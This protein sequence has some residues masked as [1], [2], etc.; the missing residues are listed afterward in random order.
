MSFQSMKTGTKLGGGFFLVIL[1]FI[2]V[3][4]YQIMSMDNLAALEG[5]SAQ[6]AVNAMNINSV[7]SRLEF[8]ASVFASAVINRDMEA[9]KKAFE[10]LKTQAAKDVE[11]VKG[12]AVTPEEKAQAEKFGTLYKE[13][14]NIFESKSLPILLKEQSMESRMRD[15]LLIKDVAGRVDS[16]YAIVAD[17][18]INRDLAASAREVEKAKAEADKDLEAVRKLADT[19]QE[20]QLA[21]TFSAAYAKYFDLIET[22]LMPALRMLAE[23]D[24]AG[25]RDVDAQ[26]DAARKESIAPL[27]AFN[28]SL[29]AEANVVAEDE[30]LLMQYD[31]EL[32]VMKDKTMEPLDAILESLT[33]ESEL[34]AERFDQVQAAAVKASI[35]GSV[36]GLLLGALIAFL[37]TR[38]LLR[39]LGG[40]PRDIA[41]T[42]SRVAVGDLNMEFHSQAKEGSVYEAMRQMV[43]AEKNV[44]HVAMKL[45][46]GDLRVTVN[47][48]SGNDE[49]MRS[50]G[51]MIAKLSE[52]VQEVSSG[53]ENVASGSEEMSA[54]SESLSQGASEQASAVEECSSSMEEMTSSINQ[55][56]DNAKQTETIAVKAAQDARESGEAVTSTVAAMKEIAGKISIIE[57]IARQTD[58]LAL[59][60]AIE[61]ARAG[62]HGKGFA[63]VASE[64]RKLAE[65][66]QT[67]AAEINRL[68]RESTTVA[69]QAGQ[70]LEKLVPDIQKTSDL[71]QEIS[72]ASAEQSTGAQQVNTALQQLDQVIQQ[73]AAASEELASTSEELSSQAEQ[74]QGS[75]GFFK[76]E[77]SE[78]KRLAPAASRTPAKALGP[79]GKKNLA[80]AKSKAKATGEFKLDLTD[81]EDSGDG[82]FERF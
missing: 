81:G 45:A 73:N 25:I 1:I 20:R 62:D 42:A 68:S 76:V 13:Y 57:E 64:V 58:L 30:K 4:A 38:D 5:E 53:A 18:V 61:A 33:K 56:A 21:D 65:R 50:L 19:D 34:A 22:R 44:A 16:L 6:L 80:A 17:A 15:A 77:G 9:S 70:L 74:L 43:A 26:I 12:L 31:G 28:A 14:L 54:S 10:E 29:E 63:V 23:G 66:S 59:N 41:E 67:A 2:G 78:P 82:Q 51:E 36:A 49:L 37:I 35:A 69:E 52:V 47:E 55:N 3:N 11:I 71:I 72:A 8:S 46:D 79:G 24:M 40:E 48:R 32:D 7:D 27:Q 60:A 75:I 39:R